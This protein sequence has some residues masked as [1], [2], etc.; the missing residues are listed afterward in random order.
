MAIVSNYANNGSSSVSSTTITL[1][2][3]VPSGQS[4]LHAVVFDQSG[5]GG[6]VLS[7]KWNGTN[8]VNTYA[9]SW[10]LANPASGTYDLVA[11]F[12]SNTTLKDLL[13]QTL[14]GT[15]TTG[16]SGTTSTGTGTGTGVISCGASLEATIPTDSFIVGFIM[17]ASYGFQIVPYGGTN[18]S[19]VGNNR[20]LANGDQAWRDQTCGIYSYNDSTTKTGWVFILLAQASG[21]ANL[22]SLN[23]NLIAN[24]K[25]IDTNL[26][27]NVKSLNTNV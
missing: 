25:S 26:I 16:Y 15:K 12:T 21:P 10:T 5:T 20:C 11:T 7:V 19:R 2:C 17:G 9:K 1:S 4:M 22:K 8:L 6:T 18:V 14:T 27:A 23:T 24:I 3:V 13:M